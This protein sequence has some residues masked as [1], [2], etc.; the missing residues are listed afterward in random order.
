M[1]HQRAESTAA[2]PSSPRARK[3]ARWVCAPVITA[4]KIDLQRENEEQPT[5]QH[6]QN[7]KATSGARHPERQDVVWVQ[8]VPHSSPLS[9]AS[10]SRDGRKEGSKVGLGVR[11]LN[12]V[13]AAPLPSTVTVCTVFRQ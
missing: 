5:Q 1:K 3:D 2:R 13:A 8:G 10:S 4:W 12:P 6:W 9:A 11:N 7:W